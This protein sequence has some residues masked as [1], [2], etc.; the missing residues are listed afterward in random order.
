MMEMTPTP[1][2]VDNDNEHYNA[3]LQ[4]SLLRQDNKEDDPCQAHG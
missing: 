4:A 2:I 1:D 3:P